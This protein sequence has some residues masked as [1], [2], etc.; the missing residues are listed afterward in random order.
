[1]NMNR[2]PVYLMLLLSGFQYGCSDNAACS[3]MDPFCQPKAKVVVSIQPARTV[4]AGEEV[5]FDA[6]DSVYDNIHWYQNAVE[7]KNCDNKDICTVLFEEAGNQIIAIE[8]VT[9]TAPGG[10]MSNSKGSTARKNIVITVT[11][12]SCANAGVDCSWDLRATSNETYLSGHALVSHDG[13]LWSLGGKFGLTSRQ[14]VFYTTSSDGRSWK[15]IA[16]DFEGTENATR[17]LWNARYCHTAL[18]FK[19][20]LWVIGGWND[21]T[22]YGDVWFST[23]G[24]HWTQASASAGWSPRRCHASVIFQNKIWIMGGRNDSN[25]F[26]D[27]WYSSDGQTWTSATASAAW[28][29]KEGLGA[30][31][32]DDKIWVFAGS[33]GN[34]SNEV[35]YSADGTNWTQAATPAWDARVHGVSLT[36]D[37]RLWLVGGKDQQDVWYSSDGQN[38][39]QESTGLWAQRYLHAG[40]VHNNRIWIMGGI[41]DDTQLGDVWSFGIDGTD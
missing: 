17:S 26:N 28:T 31:V 20:T 14:D 34:A 1:M 10:M 29:G 21:V 5:I 19:N 25:Y 18:S 11:S 22:H 4:A 27:V 12:D 38:W 39:T 2:L 3:G 36:Y 24:Y 9:E 41:R 13:K 37:S 33:D 30:A 6:S 35:W 8:A 40:T 23:N 32:L 15:N 16:M 7:I